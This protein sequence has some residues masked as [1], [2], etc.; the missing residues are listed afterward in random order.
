M[1]IAISSTG[2]DIE[3]NIGATFGRAPFFLIMDTTTKEVKV[4]EN[5][6]RERSDGI[7]ITVVNI[8]VGEKID[9]LI[10][11]DIGPSA[12]EIVERCRIKVYQAK[13][14]IKDA[15]RLFKEGKLSEIT[16]A[17][18]LKYMGLKKKKSGLR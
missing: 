16:K 1:K 4:I 12:F 8:I 5:K 2:R 7:G 6:V 18:G 14:R 13:G 15:I 3:G 10:T 9:A 17:T 11:N